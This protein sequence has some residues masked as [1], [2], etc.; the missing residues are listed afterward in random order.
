MITSPAWSRAHTPWLPTRPIAHCPP[1]S[2]PF[3]RSQLLCPLAALLP[4]QSLRRVT[5]YIMMLMSGDINRGLL[6]RTLGTL[7]NSIAAPH[8][9]S[10]VS[11]NS[12]VSSLVSLRA[13]VC[14]CEP[15]FAVSTVYCPSV[16]SLRVE[17]ATGLSLW[18]PLIHCHIKAPKRFCEWMD[19]WR[20]KEG[21]KA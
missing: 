14:S 3:L 11:L 8:F 12:L 21:K 17:N 19:E 1:A 9:P 10:E 4:R 20:K 6:T 13:L 2:P 15:L 16:H 7:F 18:T 5:V